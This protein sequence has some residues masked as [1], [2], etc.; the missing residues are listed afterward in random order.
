M[1][2]LIHL[3][4]FQNGL[5]RWYHKNGRDLPWR[6]T[7]DPYHI[8]VSE[9]MLH[10]TQVDRVIP[11]YYEFINTYPTFKALA[12]ASIKEVEQLW[13]PLGY[14]YRPRRLQE[15]AQTVITDFNGQL[16]CSLPELLA[17]PGIDLGQTDGIESNT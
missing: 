8:L 16:P 17:L 5:L 3:V 14:N 12:G 11:K 9:I 1:V 13:R 2:S 15:I 6:H 4:H 7:Q 10:Q